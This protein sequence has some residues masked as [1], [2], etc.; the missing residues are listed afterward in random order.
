MSDWKIR[1]AT[2]LRMSHKT[3]KQDQKALAIWAAE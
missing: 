3:S 1:M 2:E